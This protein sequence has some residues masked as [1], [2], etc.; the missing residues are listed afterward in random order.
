MS[1]LV[2]RSELNK[3]ALQGIVATGGGIATLIVAGISGAHWLAGVLIGGVV[4]VVGLV[5]S[6][7]KSEK[8]AGIVTAVAGAGLLVSSLP[9]LR[10]LFGWVH[11]VLIGGGIVLL[12]VGVVSLVRF[13]SGL[14]K[15][16]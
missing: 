12:G 7:S 9:F 3:R 14:R 13:F 10:G 4:G 8:T 11:G 15:R 16:M 1:D 6:G 5:L 2:P